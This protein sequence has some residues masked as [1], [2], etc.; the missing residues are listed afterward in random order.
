MS[1]VSKEA[2]TRNIKREHL[3]RRGD[4]ES[5]NLGRLPPVR[6]SGHFCDTLSAGSLFRVLLGSEPLRVPRVPYGPPRSS[7]AH[8]TLSVSNARGLRSVCCPE[9]PPEFGHCCVGRGW[10]QL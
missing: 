10:L 6:A 1:V 9:D 4:S 5:R 2:H 7:P 8:E 3:E